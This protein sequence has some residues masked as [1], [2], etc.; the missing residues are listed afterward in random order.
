MAKGGGAA[1]WKGVLRGA[2]ISLGIYLIGTALL[3]SLIVKRVIPEQGGFPA[4]ASLC[5][6][7]ALCGGLFTTPLLPPIPG[8]MAAAACFC[9]ILAVFGGACWQGI[10]WMGHG[11][12]LLL[13]AA[14]GGLLAGMLSA[15]RRKR[16]RKG[17]RK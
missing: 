3:A 8:S 17:R 6:L 12:I 13:C 4:I 9:T 15:R 10:S 16:R 1:P 7:A 14:A 5:L 2:G 11:G